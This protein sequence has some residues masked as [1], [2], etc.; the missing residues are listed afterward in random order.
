MTQDRQLMDH[1][2]LAIQYAIECGEYRT[3]IEELIEG[4]NDH[5]LPDG[6]VLKARALLSKFCDEN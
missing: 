1:R 4:R 3:F 2:E 5:D 6:I